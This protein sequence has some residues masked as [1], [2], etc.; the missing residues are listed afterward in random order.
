MGSVALPG[1]LVRLRDGLPHG[2]HCSLGVPIHGSTQPAA[3][4]KH[5]KPVWL[6]Q[7]LRQHAGRTRQDSQEIHTGLS[8]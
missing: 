3:G 1:E 2:G 8:D 6:R 7:E 4:F 5:Q